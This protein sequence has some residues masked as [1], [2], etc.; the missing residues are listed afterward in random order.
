MK[1]KVNDVKRKNEKQEKIDGR[2]NKRMKKE[3][4]AN[5]EKICFLR[6]GKT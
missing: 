2:G 3:G 1:W 4:K 6:G 5:K